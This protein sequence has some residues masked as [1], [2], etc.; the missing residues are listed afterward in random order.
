MGDSQRN[1]RP[2]GHGVRREARSAEWAS[3]NI[4][5]RKR[6]IPRIARNDGRVGLQEKTVR[7]GVACSRR[8]KTTTAC[9]DTVQRKELRLRRW[10]G[11]RQHASHASGR[12]SGKE[13]CPSKEYF[14]ASK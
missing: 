4:A 9:R 7:K 10:C 14:A 13:R 6:E 2:V 12:R 11:P 1:D 3:L 5:A 8:E